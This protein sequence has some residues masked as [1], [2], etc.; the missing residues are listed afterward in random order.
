MRQPA[1]GLTFATTRTSK[2]TTTAIVEATGKVSETSAVC[3]GLS[4]ERQPYG[5]DK[6]A[7]S[8]CSITVEAVFVAGST[9][10][11]SSVCGRSANKTLLSRAT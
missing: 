1:V 9:A 3:V 4:A 7:A 10:V 5:S 2:R 6:R 11:R 8:L